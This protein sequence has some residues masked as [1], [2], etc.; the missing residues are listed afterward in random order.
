[1]H[2]KFGAA[3]TLRSQGVLVPNGEGG[4]RALLED[5]AWAALRNF[6]TKA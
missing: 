2:G 5:L 4:R 1:V 6:G 3:V